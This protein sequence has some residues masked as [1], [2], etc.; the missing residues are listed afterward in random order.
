MK[1]KAKSIMKIKFILPI[2]LFVIFFLLIFGVIFTLMLFL[3]SDKGESGKG[4]IG[5]IGNN[6]LVNEEIER[7]RP[8]FEK[9]AKLYG[10]PN[11]VE[12]LMVIAMQESGGRHLD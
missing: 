4:G 12:L 11:H 8:L 3:S 2:S 7:L 6:A 10:I 9:Y 1:K 5:D